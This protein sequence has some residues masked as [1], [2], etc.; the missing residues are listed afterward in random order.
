MCSGRTLPARSCR[1][2]YA[3]ISL[4]QATRSSRS[5]IQGEAQ[6]D[7]E[8]E[9][10]P[11]GVG[12]DLRREARA[13]CSG[14]TGSWRRHRAHPPYPP[15]NVKSSSARIDCQASLPLL[16]GTKL[17]L[18]G[19]FPP[20]QMRFL[21]ALNLFNDPPFVFERW[22]YIACHLCARRFRRNWFAAI[23]FWRGC[24]RGVAFRGTRSCRWNCGHL[25][26]STG[27]CPLAAARRSPNRSSLRL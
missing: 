12:D 15:V 7:R 11:D 9:I 10:E 8:R 2:A 24:F 5:A 21:M 6:A 14:A 25:L 20:R 23:R 4:R 19:P 13:L 17:F 18:S 26:I 3:P 1:L 27:H 22:R 16:T